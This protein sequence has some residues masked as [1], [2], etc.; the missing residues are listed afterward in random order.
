[1]SQIPTVELGLAAVPFASLAALRAAE[2]RVVDLRSPAEFAV[3][4]LPGA[5][6]VP[7]FDDQERAFVGLLYKQFSPEA[8]FAEGR[9]VVAQKIEA[10]VGAVAE[11]IDWELPRTGLDLRARVL[12]M[13]E[14]GIGP[15]D[16]ELRA[17]PA[18]PLPEA[19]VALHCWR[20]GLRSRSVLALVRALGL[21]RAVGLEG[22]Y[23]SWRQD[24]LERLARWPG[25]RRTVVLR[26]LTGVGKTLV[27][28]EI[29][30]LRPGST[31]DLEGLAGHR[32]SLLGMVGLEPV[33]QKAFESALSERL[34]SGFTSDVMFVEGE[35]RK[36]GD[37]VIPVTVWDALRGGT[38]V[39]IEASLARRVDVLIEDYLARPDA[40]QQLAA[41]LA[42]VASRMPGGPDLPGMLA[43]GETRELVELLL[44]AYYDPLYRH[45]EGARTYALCIDASDVTAAAERV[46]AFVAE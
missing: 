13:T 39:W 33:S 43:R 11:A 10:F 19:P 25:V 21:E 22:G 18:G 17:V 4:H 14:R 30:R 26:G 1:M 46:L 38:D 45:S 20:G 31:L 37:V 2:A 23:K 7:L 36:V 34:I 16:V 3:D 42:V 15:L 24:V 8:A 12:A 28:R 44:G 41:Q 5:I 29:E 40:Q 35:S 9:T 6:N 32:S 27:L